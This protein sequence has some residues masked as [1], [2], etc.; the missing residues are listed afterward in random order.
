[1]AIPF[2]AA[3]RHVCLAGRAG[4]NCI[5][6]SRIVMS[7][8]PETAAPRSVLERPKSPTEWLLRLIFGPPI[9]TSLQEETRLRKLLALPIFSSD[10]ISS[11]AYATQEILLALGAAG[12]AAAAFR[13]V[14][15]RATW[16]VIIAIVFLLAIVTLSYRQTI[17]AYPSGGGS[18]VVS[19]ENLGVGAGLV[20]AAALL[21]DYVLTVAVSIAAGV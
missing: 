19:K 5:Q 8:R 10:A 2:S 11:V 9:A 4:S 6:E 17:F 18:Y 15:V 7:T 12:L 14:Y 21:I 3:S 1:M 20:A 13:G 16:E